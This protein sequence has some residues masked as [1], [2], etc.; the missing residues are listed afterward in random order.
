MKTWSQIV[1]VILLFLILASVVKI[2]S[3][4]QVQVGKWQVDGA[5]LLNTVSGEVW[6]YKKVE[7]AF[8]PIKREFMAAWML[9][10]KEDKGEKKEQ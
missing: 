2:A 5:F 7:D 1:I 8:T 9:R 10:R 3:R 4:S 6:M